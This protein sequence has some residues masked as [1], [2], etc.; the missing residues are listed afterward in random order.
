MKRILILLLLMVFSCQ[1]TAKS[2]VFSAPV[3][4][5]PQLGEMQNPVQGAFLPSGG[6]ALWLP[7]YWFA[8]GFLAVDLQANEVCLTSLSGAILYGWP[9]SRA[10]AT[11]SI[12]PNAKVRLLGVG[13][14]AWTEMMLLK[15]KE[16]LRLDGKGEEL[17]QFGYISSLTTGMVAVYAQGRNMLLPREYLQGALPAEWGSGERGQ[18]LYLKSDDGVCG[19]TM[20]AP[21]CWQM[22]QP[23]AGLRLAAFAETSSALQFK[24]LKVLQAVAA[25]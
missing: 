13:C 22:R 16:P 14:W 10:V 15:A 4:K 17:R 18:W 11:G 12:A 19:W 6:G 3:F 23:E 7:Q 21:E 5:P 9:D 25:E 8:E 2:E 24:P 20:F 1:A